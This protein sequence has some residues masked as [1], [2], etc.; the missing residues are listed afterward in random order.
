[1]SGWLLPSA[2]AAFWAGIALA[3]MI[4]L[5][6]PPSWTV[7]VIGLGGLAAAG[8]LA[9]VRTTGPDPVEGA[10]LVPTG[11]GATPLGGLAPPRALGGRGPPLLTVGL[12]AVSMLALGAGW[13]GLRSGW[14]ARAG[15]ALE[16]VPGGPLVVEG[17]LRDDPRAGPYGWWAILEVRLVRAD[18]GP[19]DAVEWG[20]G[21]APVLL[22]GDGAPPQAVRWDRLR[23][24][25]HL[26]LRGPDVPEF[27]RANGALGV[28]QVDAQR[29]LGPAANPI[30]RLVQGIRA[31]LHRGI[32]RGFP[33]RD[34]GLLLGL[35]LGDDS[36]LHPALEEDFRATG[37]GHLL[38]VSGQNVAMVLAPVIGL[39]VLLRTSGRTRFAVGAGTVVLFVLLTGAEP[40]VLRAGV[41]AVVT[42]AGVLA[43][44]PRSSATALGAAV[45]VLLVADPRLTQ[46]IGFQLSVAATAGILSLATPIA[47]RLARL[48]RPIALAAATTL[49]AQ[50]GVSP[51]LLFHFQQVPLVTLPANLLAFPA[52]APAM[53]LGLTAAGVGQLVPPMGAVL[54]AVAIVPLR[55]LQA[56]ADR[57]ASAPVASVTTDRAGVATV[58]VGIGL[59]GSIAWWLRSRRPLPRG[60]VVAAAALLPLL[61][62]ST[63]LGVGPPSSLT[64]RFLDVG[65]GD[66]AV[67][68]TPGGAVVL[69][70]AGPEPDQ[71]ATRL[72]ALGVKR[73][74]LAV[75]T[76]PHADHV[77]GFPA[78]LARFP[79]SL[80]IEPGCPEPSP[81]YDAFLD[82]VAEEDVPVRHPRQGDVLW[83]GDLRVDVL[84]PEACYEGTDSD[85]NNDSLVLRL[86]HLEDTALFTGDVEEPS[87]EALLEGGVPLRAP[88]LKVPH[89]GG[90]TSLAE[91]FLAVDADVAIVSTGPNDYGH[92]APEVLAE[93]ERTGAEVL[94]TDLAGDVVVRFLPEG[95]SVASAAA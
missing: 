92:P 25:G 33:D 26:A 43:G 80:L 75:A 23:V 59:V 5:G 84:S 70:D 50:A 62:W 60:L 83:V 94:R 69:V 41:M 91:F 15:S 10:G 57:L 14:D 22:D 51:L 46:S 8:A 87:Q 18:P 48:P 17:V 90:N 82:A 95:V 47:E 37:L 21:G 74:D 65:Q 89:H 88:V 20:L 86:T 63:A 6:G 29:R 30:L 72:A 66:A 39:A 49:A 32:D 42:L 24:E 53:L 3:G 40:S 27:A 11:P 9:P 56:L 45:L 68:T 81:S 28:L 12:V 1:V 79:V 61:V 76:H 67:V 35:A 93:L 44:R 52:V 36:R 85:A 73:I 54:V 64:L 55:Y 38:A 58:V 2:A 7:V 77:E 13:S 4:G 78:I 31:I 71:V 16:V 34:S 19:P